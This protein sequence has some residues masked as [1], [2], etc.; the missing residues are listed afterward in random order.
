[1]A[2]SAPSLSALLTRSRLLV[3]LGAVCLASSFSAVANGAPLTHAAAA[4]PATTAR[5]TVATKS[6]DLV[7][8]P[9]A[10]VDTGVTATPGLMG[11]MIAGTNLIGSGGTTDGNGHGTAMASISSGAGIGVCGICT[12]MPV[13]VVGNA[14]IGTTQLATQG[15]IW[16]AAHGARVINLSLTMSS[17]DAGLTTAIANAVSAGV[18]VVVAAGN[19]GST[20]PSAQGYPGADTPEAISVASSNGI[21]GL[22][23][24]SNYG[25]WVQLA[26]PGSL[27]ASTTTGQTFTAIGTSGSAAYVSGVVGLM[28]SCNPTLTPSQV[29]SILLSTGTPLPALGPNGHIVDAAVAVAA[30]SPTQ[31]CQAAATAV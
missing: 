13:R 2:V 21:L 23:P 20:D 25:S 5:S 17:G 11:R 28:L 30:S 31:A 4:A 24:W 26:A 6:G 8:V 9:I 3:G 18:V 29:Q 16:A 10:I 15:V 14:G 27:I 12:I 19:D 22:F 7:G 1:M